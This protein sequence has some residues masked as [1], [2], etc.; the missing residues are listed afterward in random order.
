MHG[1]WG[2][3]TTEIL[4]QEVVDIEA[5]KALVQKM[6]DDENVPPMFHKIA[7]AM[8]MDKDVEPFVHQLRSVWRMI[9]VWC[10]ND[11]KVWLRNWERKA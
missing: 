10:N 11:S 2:E 6:I 5:M 7:R 8:I 1:K 4:K 9:P 3:E